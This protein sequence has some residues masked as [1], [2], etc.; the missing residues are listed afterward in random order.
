ML[1]QVHAG[2]FANGISALQNCWVAGLL[3]VWVAG[4]LSFWIAGFLVTDLLKTKIE[5]A[6]KGTQQS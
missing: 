2:A 5:L 4:F 3:S 6:L 1:F